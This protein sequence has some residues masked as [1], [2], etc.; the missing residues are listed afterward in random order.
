MTEYLTAS[1]NDAVAHLIGGQFPANALKS[2]RARASDLTAELNKAIVDEIPAFSESRNPEILPA[3]SA[4]CHGHVDEVFRLLGGGPIGS[5]EFVRDNA[6]KLAERRFPLEAILHAYRCGH[7]IFAHR[8]REATLAAMG[9]SHDTRQ[10]A[11]SVAD[12]AM[13]YANAVST[14][15]AGV[16]VS[17]TRLM[18]DV[19]GDRRTQLLNILL[20]GYDESDGRASGILRDAGYLDHR[21]S[22]CVVLAQSTDPT[23]MLVPAR[24]RRLADS[25]DE[26]LHGKVARRLSDIRDNK[27]TVICS[28]IRR[29]S[30]WTPARTDLARIIAHELEVVGPAVLIG[31]SNDVPSTSLIPTAYRQAQIAL[32]F[33][34]VA[35]R[36]MHFSALAP[37]GLLLHLAGEEFRRVL[38]DWTTKFFQADEKARGALVTTLRAYANADMNILKTAETLLV[39]PNTIYSRMQKIFDITGLEARSYHALTELL[40]IADCRRK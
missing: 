39:H 7:K 28:D 15:T 3:L 14:I 26:A 23:E 37:Q 21:Q 27:A 20:G 40:L 9:P 4:H 10:L 32:D 11:A 5:F 2:M 6:R 29:T 30:G 34:N 31:L 13:E 35:N 36:V 16:Y 1:L 12:F 8:L 38:P 19:A 24:A 22:F 17:Q 25:I 33:A 18:A